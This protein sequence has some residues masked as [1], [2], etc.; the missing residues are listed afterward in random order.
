[1]PKDYELIPDSCNDRVIKQVPRPPQRPLSYDRI[2]PLI[3]TDLGRERA[4]VPDAELI[5]NWQYAGGNLS[6]SAFLAVISHAGSI[7]RKEPNLVRVEGKVLV[8]GDIH[9]QFY[10]LIELLRKQ[11]IGGANF[12]GK[13]VV[14]LGDYVDRGKY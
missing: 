12:K 10:D 11:K 6:K 7:L 8:V 1:M 4:E 14:F 3:K 9:G 5:K 2:Y 13:K